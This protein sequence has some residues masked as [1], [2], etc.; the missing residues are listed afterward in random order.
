MEGSQLHDDGRDSP[1]QEEPQ[2]DVE[3]DADDRAE[4]VRTRGWG[5]GMKEVAP[6]VAYVE[7]DLAAYFAEFEGLTEASQV[8]I[9]RTYA[10]YLAARTRREPVKRRKRSAW[11]PQYEEP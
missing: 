10:N 2:E 1:H 8:A 7:P 11:Q 6:S 3:S 4:L 9:C 5:Y